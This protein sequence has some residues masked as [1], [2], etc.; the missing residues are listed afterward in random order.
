[1]RYGRLRRIIA[2][3]GYS[4]AEVARLSGMEEEYFL[5][6]ME[7]QEEFEPEE[8]AALATVLRLGSAE[9]QDDVFFGEEEEWMREVNERSALNERLRED[10]AVTLIG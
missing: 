7:Q 10:E 8:Y 9:A 2:Q 3:E 4:E 6:T 1:M 5:R